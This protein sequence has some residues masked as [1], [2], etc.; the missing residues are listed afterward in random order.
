MCLTIPCPFASW[1][2]GPI[3]HWLSKGLAPVAARA[4]SAAVRV[5][6]ALHLLCPQCCRQPACPSFSLSRVTS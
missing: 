4:A 3:L 5:Q 1:G 2:F 6:Q